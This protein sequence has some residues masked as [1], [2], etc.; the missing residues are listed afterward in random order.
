MN[1]QEVSADEFLISGADIRTAPG[2]D[3][4]LIMVDLLRYVPLNV[5]QNPGKKLKMLI[6][7]R[8]ASFTTGLSQGA[9]VQ[10]FF[11]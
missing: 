3:A 7:G 8:A 9:E 11:E 6:N 2:K 10:L 5:E 1:G 4:E